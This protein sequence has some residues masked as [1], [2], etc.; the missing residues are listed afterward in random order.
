M[1]YQHVSVIRVYYNPCANRKISVGKLLYKNRQIYF[2]YDN[3]FVKS[4]LELSPFKL[5]LKTGV[6]INEDKLF[7]GLYG[8]FNDSLPDGWGRLLLDRKLMQLGINPGGLSALDRLAYVGK[9]GMGALTY[10]PEI[11]EDT[12]KLKKD[13]DLISKEVMAVQENTGDD[14]VDE[15]LILNGS[16]AGARPK[17]LVNIKGIDWIIKFRSS[18]DPIDI[19][20]IEYAYYLMAKE[21]KLKVPEAKI[22]Q[23]K[24]S[25]YGYFGV[26][27]FDRGN[28]LEKRIHMHSMSGLL[29]IDHRTPTLDYEN[30]MRVTSILTKNI[31]LC[32]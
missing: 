2:E 8:L 11:K 32:Q 19:S 25:S 9:H 21:A 16:S 6:F 3:E 13:L 7:E 27:R 10:E 18:L 12:I 4:K 24:I 30:I 5:P 23:S 17:I 1:S 15:L 29:N 26:Q 28:S 14:F 31:R 22:F 20:S